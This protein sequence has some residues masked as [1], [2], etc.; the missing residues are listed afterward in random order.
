VPEAELVLVKSG[1]PL[2]LLE[3]LLHGPPLAG[4]LDQ[5]GQGHQSGG[6]AVE[7]RQVSGIVLRR[8]S[9]QWR[10]ELVATS[11]H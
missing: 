5:D 10:G 3:A 6:V 7:E 9:S 8:I 2:A 4:D 1:L 11:A